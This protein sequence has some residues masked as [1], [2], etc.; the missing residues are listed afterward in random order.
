[1]PTPLFEKPLHFIIVHG[2]IFEKLRCYDNIFIKDFNY[3]NFYT[4][5]YVC[6]KKNIHRHKQK[7]L[8][9]ICTFTNLMV[10]GR[11]TQCQVI[12]MILTCYAVLSKGFC[13]CSTDSYLAR[14]LFFC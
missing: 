11:Y 14:L 9:L 12:L 5:V 1:M 2:R 7:C 4:L 6:F 13:V 10:Q 8:F 3:S